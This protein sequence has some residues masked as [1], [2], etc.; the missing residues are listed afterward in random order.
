MKDLTHYKNTG[1]KAD[2]KGMLSVTHRMMFRL[3]LVREDDTVIITFRGYK[4]MSHVK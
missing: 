2:S 1:G 3:S 4:P